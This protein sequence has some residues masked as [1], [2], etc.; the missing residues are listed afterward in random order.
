MSWLNNMKTGKKVLLLAGILC[1]AIVAG[2]AVGVYSTSKIATV[3]KTLYEKHMMGLSEIKE[4]DVN[5]LCLARS[6]R[7]ALV[8]D[9][10]KAARER[11]LEEGEGFYKAMMEHINAADKTIVTDEVK[12]KMAEVK[13]LTGPYM[14]AV[15]RTYR[16][17]I[18]DKIDEA[19]A[20]MLKFAPT[21]NALTKAFAELAKSKENHRQEV[22]R[23]RRGDVREHPQHVDRDD[24]RRHG[25]GPRVRL[26]HR[27]DDRKGTRGADRRGESPDRGGRRRQTPN[28]RQP[29]VG[30]PGVPPHPRR[31]Q[32]HAGRRD[33]P[34]ERGRRIHR[35]HLQGRHSRRR[36][37]TPTTATSTR[38][39]TTS[40][41]ASTRST[42]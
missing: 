3:T 13:D 28:P 27:P 42:D 36:S 41:S 14:D 31:R 35:S 4:A 6:Y 20:E 19:K 17:A 21:A 40:T 37:P 15:R 7:N 29:R 2:G 32:R 10:D 30:E 12:A 39:R 33:R 26:V 8:I 22:L 16:L 11:R 25:R 24:R 23:R 38:S 1:A 5:I 18:D 34:I 9:A